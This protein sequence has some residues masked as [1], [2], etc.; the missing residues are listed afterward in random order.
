ML[1]VTLAACDIGG[2]TCRLGLFHRDGSALVLTARQDVPTADVSDVPALF[3]AIQSAFGREA[4]SSCAACAA[5]CAG[6]VENG[7]VRLSNAAAEYAEGQGAPVPFRIVND[8][9]AVA[10]S[11]LTP[12]GE[13][14]LPVLHCGMKS[15]GQGVM[16]AIGPGT[17][18]G[19]SVLIPGKPPRVMPSEG[20][21]APFPFRGR[22]ERAFEDFLLPRLGGRAFAETDDVV[23]GRGLEALHEFLSGKRMPASAIGPAYLSDDTTLRVM[24]ASFLARACRAFMLS[25]LCFGGL[26]IAGGLALRNPGLVTCRAFRDELL[27]ETKADLLR[28]MPV[29]LFR[30][31]DCGLWGAAGAASDLAASLSV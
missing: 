4:L 1:P 31:D 29:R 15:S 26:W 7:R 21:H 9:A 28:Q 20:G 12:A 2:T 30:S 17:G 5:A 6:P 25:S 23:S 14:A 8:F 19:C 13:A 3:A 24:F 11:I 27:R 22:E 18:F 16:A 10:R